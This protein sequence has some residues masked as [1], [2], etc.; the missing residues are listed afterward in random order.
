MDKIQKIFIADLGLSFEYLEIIKKIS[1]KI[2]II[3]TNTNIENSKEIY[4][5]GWIDAVSQKTAIL[6]MLVEGGHTPVVMIDSD[7]IVVEDFA[8]I[9]DTNYD[10]QLCKR[11][12]PLIRP[13]GLLVEYIASFVSINNSNGKTF[14]AAWISRIEER[15][16][17]NMIPPHETPA[18]VETL[19]Q[20]S[21]LKIGSVDDKIASCEN[22]YFPNITRIIHAKGRTKRDSIS[23]FRF[24]NIKKLPYKKV[25]NLFD[26]GQILP[27]TVIYIF[28][29]IF[30]LYELK[31]KIKQII[32]FI[33]K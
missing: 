18:M 2:E 19:R 7:T 32:I 23:I 31:R 8:D 26:S 11:T 17:L 25:I 14:I 3:N 22:N 5:K 10:I 24:A 1:A 27:F 28:K 21:V 16:G 29:K 20:N 6:Q 13:D 4:S 12:T 15:I 33:K 30:S 9:I